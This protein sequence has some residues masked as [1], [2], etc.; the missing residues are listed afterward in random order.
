MKLSTV[1][2]ENNAKSPLISVVLTAY[3]R[4]QFI[5]EALESVLNQ[6][7]PSDEYEIII[8]KNFEHD[9]IDSMQDGS[10][11]QCVSS[12]EA[13]MGKFMLSGIRRIRGT[14]I[15]FMEDDD[16]WEKE[17]L[18]IVAQAFQKHCELGYFHNAVLPI[19]EN[20]ETSKT[21]RSFEDQNWKEGDSPM[22]IEGKSKSKYLNR[23][24]KHFP[25]FNLSSI[26]V[27]RDIL[28]GNEPSL[29][30]META[31]D[32]F[33]LILALASKRSILLTP[34]RG[35][36][37]RQHSRNQSGYGKDGELGYLASMFNFTNRAIVPYAK[38]F[39]W[40]RVRNARTA[41]RVA[42]RRYRFTQVLNSIQNPET[43]RWRTFKSMLHFIRFTP[44]FYPWLNIKALTLA[45]AYIV[46]PEFSRRLLARN[47]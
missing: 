44:Y 22:L 20:G 26:S 13:S 9:G 31:I 32:T 1:N 27:H 11:I 12:D 28:E 6:T 5:R 45:L 43:S 46:D 33:L 10:R 38:M 37:Y 25:D 42:G 34:Y 35:T 16:I 39:R 24:G 29:E 15:S 40:A 7:L 4:R 47:I 23:M 19:T 2:E 17:R 41:A 14:I 8:V 3:N 30:V 21:V 18:E 36:R